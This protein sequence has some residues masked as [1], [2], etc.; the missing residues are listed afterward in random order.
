MLLLAI[1]K[2]KEESIDKKKKKNS[3]IE[4]IGRKEVELQVG[5]KIKIYIV[6][7]R[8]MESIHR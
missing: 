3:I 7:Q 2:Y 4:S 1:R 5:I 6:S 8:E